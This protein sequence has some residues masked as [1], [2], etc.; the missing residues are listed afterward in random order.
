[1][2]MTNEEKFKILAD[3]IKIAEHLDSEILTKSELTR[4]DVKTVDRSWVFQITFPY[5]LAIEDYLLFTSAITEEFKS[6]A[7]VKCNITIKDKANQDEYAI[8]YFSHCI[9][10]T[11][12]S[13]K[14]KGQLKQK[15]LIMSGDILKV[16]CQNDVERDHFD[17]ACNGSLIAAYQQCGFSISKVVFE[18]DSAVNNG[19]LASLEAHIQEEDE[20]SA[21]EATEKL[22]KMKAEKAKQQDN[23]ESSVSKCQI[24]KP[25]Q[26]E[27]VRTIDSIIEEEFKV[28]VEGVIFD[29]NLKELKSGR[30]I[31]EIKV[32][33]YTDSLVLKMFT[34]KN[35]DDLAHFKALSVGKWVRA[36]GRIEEDTFVR[37]LVMMMSD[38]EEIKKATK[39]D[40]AEEKRVEFHLHTSMSQMDGIPN[41]STYVDQ[42]AKWGHKA[43][44]VTDHNVVQAFPDAHAAAEKNGIK[45]IYGM[46]GMLVDDG[47]P[48]AYKPKDC[49]LKTATYVVF[50][51]ETTGL[52]NQYDKI[53]ELAAV[54]VKD[55]EI[56][57]KF[58][59]FS[60]PHER[61]SET[62]KNLTHISDD[63]L[64][65]AP[66]IEEVLT[67]FKSWVGDAIFV[68][69][70]AS[71]DMG[72]I[73]TGYEHVGIGAST[74]GVI[75][76]LEL[77]R[78]INTEYGKHGLNFLAKKY[79]VELTQ[80]HRAIY[81]TEATAYMFIKMLK[82]LEELGVHNHQDINTSLTNEDA[83]KR[84]RPNHV[85]LIVQNQEGLKNLFKI[86]SASLVQYYYR[87]PRIP[88]SLLDEHREGILVGSACD[89]GEV[90][91]AV[92]QKDQSQV[93]RIA[94][95]YDF[96]E[97]QPPALYQDLIDRELV[98]DNETLHEI[99]NR[100]IRAGDVNNIPVISTGNA[101]Y[102]N[103][104]DAIARKIL[105][106][107]QP[108][109]PL[110]RSTLP[111][112]HFRTT[113]EML[114]ELHFLGEEKAYE[115]VI[116]NT[117]EL[118]DKIERVVPIKDELY[119]P[120]ME[121]AND[122]IREMSYNN[123]KALY[124]EDLPQIV[125]DRL[126]K[127]LESIIGNGFSVIYLISQRLVKKSL[128]DGYLVGSRGSVGSSFV[129]TMTEITEVNPLPPHYICPECKNSEF[130][131]DGS[132]GS[133]FDLPDKKCESCG[134]DLIKEG[135][136]IPFETFLGFKGDK[137]PDIDLNFSGEYQPEAH[138]YTKELFGEDKVFR[139]GTIGTVAEKTAFGFVKGY[140][141][142]QGIHKRGAE[143]DRLVKGC[144]GV[145]RTTGQHPGGIIV[146]PDYMD[147]YDFTPVQFPADDQASSWMTT[148]FDFHSIHDNVLKLDILGHDDPTMIRMLQDLSG[149]DP[150]TIPVDDKETMGIFSSPEPLGVT[151]EEILCKT[152]TFG[153]PEFGTGFVRQM[154]EDTKPT[155]FSELVRISGLSHGTDVWLGNAQDLIRSG[156]CD[157]ASVICCRDDIMVY[158]MY[159]G[160]EPSLAFKTMEFVRKGK[161]LT[162]DM[163]EAMV[164]NEVPDWYLD[165]CRKIKYMFPKAHAAA[166]VLMAVRIAYFK[167]HYPLYYY[168]SYFTVRA[169]DFDLISMIK[170]KESIRNTVND[171]YSRYM[172]LA[173]KEKDTLTVLEIMNEMA[174]RGFRMQPISLEKSKAFEFII[175]GDTLIPPFIS[176]PG[177]GE[178]V[179]QRIVEAREEGPFLSKEDLNKKAGL[180]QK[181][182]EY[183]D[184]L[185]SLPN[186]P[187]KAQL[188]IFDM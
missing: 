37:D 167:V 140:L 20:K 128:N 109:N 19:D 153:V 177:L 105:I 41:I 119:T 35:K 36:Q 170:D 149:I 182:I 56:I 173:K 40:K 111:Q 53:I 118:A 54:K 26:I 133:G 183:L 64:V 120:R 130:F 44:A 181:V 11:K 162:D 9:D 85:T 55:G 66:E 91:T 163:V 165:S 83:Y 87:T 77:S 101:H 2:S 144:T 43:I 146:V 174:Q 122:E 70:N 24:G 6:I 141:N 81:D 84:A 102:L 135:Q 98:R 169:S 104:H 38:I 42:A 95:Y 136:D 92:M 160:L 171:M 60:N 125:I 74:N 1:M 50:D 154:L 75:D 168:A 172:D 13:P 185:G 49:N 17:K 106:A 186:L 131:N 121:G 88:R 107:S 12:L 180:S 21:R 150:K 39:Q 158:L 63:M 86:V 139:A 5:F 82:Q 71:F 4:V 58:E 46:E 90:F 25:I 93:E 69:H 45:M 68:A 155:T 110:N 145:K 147:I 73:D 143:I 10:Q 97:V 59:R 7:E 157:L 159:N 161:G 65:D 96:I 79:G 31:V 3:Q 142:D 80:H 114:D 132:V 22:E 103:E 32:T 123:A 72:F 112:A 187:D 179:A 137:V 30:H 34:R 152:G 117:N 52:S 29:I 99:Y 57:D 18:T 166:Y 134:C 108:G 94:K 27:N 47:V 178:N 151:S 62:I 51:V 129:A 78:T 48:I 127:E 138:N 61:L 148:H 8:K 28:A 89:E 164:D 14:V 23:N 126:E 67:E 115:L 15:R 116:K 16:M 124:G 100:L 176:V 156:K 184:E 76:T 33:D 175:E 113:D 188:S